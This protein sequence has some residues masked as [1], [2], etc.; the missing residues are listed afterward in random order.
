MKTIESIGSRMMM[1]T[2]P[3]R[4]LWTKPL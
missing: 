2:A 1:T 4:A 3:N